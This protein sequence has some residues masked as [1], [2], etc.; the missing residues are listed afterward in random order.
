M[1]NKSSVIKVAV[2]AIVFG[3][4]KQ[5]GVSVL[6]IQRKYEPY[7]NSWAIPGGFVLED[8]SLEEAVKRELAEE[9]GIT[10]N[11]LEQLY[12]FGEPKRD[13]RQRIIAV[14]YFGLVKASQYQELKASTDA[15]NAKWFS[16]KKL[17]TLAF[18]HK[19]ILQVAIERLRAKVR[20]QPVGFELL[21]KKFPFSDLEKLYTALLDKEINRR[22]FSK[23]ILSFDFLEE[24]GEL[25]KSE[26]KGRPSKMYQFN[27]K[28]Y[29]ELLKEGF[30]FEI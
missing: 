2:D 20:Y 26:G 14:A 21:D 30:H 28:R 6:L 17:P 13:P 16:I 18:D 27:Q 15:E 24:T 12:T 1:Q 11:Y 7:K 22:N 25:S 4:S 29:K 10:V 3:Y 5:D 8:E 9:T 23:K 19:Q